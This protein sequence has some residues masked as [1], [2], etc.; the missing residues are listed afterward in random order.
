MTTPSQSG[1]LKIS[2]S[3][4]LY[5]RTNSGKNDF[6]LRRF[7]KKRGGKR[8]LWVKRDKVGAPTA[9]LRLPARP[10]TYPHSN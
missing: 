6:Y 8:E 3:C 7:L 5:M 10:P 9:P 1:A 2:G 4:K